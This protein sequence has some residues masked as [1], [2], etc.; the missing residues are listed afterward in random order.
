MKK[1]IIFGTG[2]FGE[3]AHFYFTHDTSHQVVAFTAHKWAIKKET[4][5]DLP[6][7][8][9]EDIVTK[10]P[11][12]EFSMFIAVVYTNLNKIRAKI[13]EEAKTKGYELISYISSKA[14]TWTKFK[15]GENCF[16]FENNVIQP[17][18]TIGDDVI[19]WSG[20]HIGHHSKIGNHCFIASHVV[21]SG[22]VKIKPYCFLGVNSTIRDGITIAEGS[23]IGAGTTI[24]K[25]TKENHAYIANS[26]NEIPITDNLLKRL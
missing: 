6:V 17:Y 21:I 9:F 23:L 5:L 10:Y 18:V 3:L 16:I 26:P 2:D 13:F 12:S 11:P 25:D 15:I 20:N 7:V 8:P 19:L 22:R 4:L 1:I 14:T 24:L